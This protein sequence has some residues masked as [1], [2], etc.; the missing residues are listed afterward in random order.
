MRIVYISNV[1]FL[2]KYLY[3]QSEYSPTWDSKWLDLIAQMIRVFGMNPKVGGSSP[4][5]VETFFVLKIINKW[6]QRRREISI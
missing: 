1:N 3:C 6:T 2:Q 4:P 5:E